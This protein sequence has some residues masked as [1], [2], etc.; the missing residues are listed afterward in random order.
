MEHV[1]ITYMIEMKG[2]LLRSLPMREVRHDLQQ[3]YA[4]VF[5]PVLQNDFLL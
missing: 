3:I 5:L 1:I 4:Q 2:T